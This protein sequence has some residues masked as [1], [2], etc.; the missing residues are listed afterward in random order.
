MFPVT[1]VTLLGGW[2]D[3]GEGVKGGGCGCC[4]GGCGAGVLVVALVVTTFERMAVVIFVVA[5]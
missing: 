1:S 4:C 5:L 2:G 3:G